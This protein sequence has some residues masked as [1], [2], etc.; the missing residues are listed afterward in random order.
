MLCDTTKR[1]ASWPT[2]FAKSPKKNLICENIGAKTRT[3]SGLYWFRE[4]L[5]V[6]S[7][8]DGRQPEYFL[9][10]WI[11][12]D[13]WFSLFMHV[14]FFS[15]LGIIYISKQKQRLFKLVEGSRCSARVSL[16]TASLCTWTDPIYV[17][18]YVAWPHQMLL[19]LPASWNLEGLLIWILSWDS[20]WTG[21]CKKMKICV[22]SSDAAPAERSGSGYSIQGLTTCTKLIWSCSMQLYL[23]FL[24][25]SWLL[26]SLLRQNCRLQCHPKFL[27]TRPA[28]FCLAFVILKKCLRRFVA[29]G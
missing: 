21:S 5:K 27:M 4:Q 15:A 6:A 7:K 9:R 17:H 23:C 20:G 14:W 29:W 19:C 2:W 25:N 18:Y 8:T 12:T 11:C 1:S 16:L 26:I 28:H 3:E 13:A 24:R 10:R 22:L